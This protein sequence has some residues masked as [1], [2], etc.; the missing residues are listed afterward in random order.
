M[1]TMGG[2]GSLS[3]SDLSNTEP[4]KLLVDQEHVGGGTCALH[5]VV[6]DLSLGATPAYHSHRMAADGR[7]TT[8]SHVQWNFGT[9]RPPE[10]C[11]VNATSPRAMAAL[12]HSIRKPRQL[13]SLPHRPLR[14]FCMW[15]FTLPCSP[16]GAPRPASTSAQTAT[17]LSSFGAERAIVLC[18]FCHTRLCL[19]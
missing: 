12:L 19:S 13:L 17:S 4:W 8:L 6:S 7:D 14:C 16:K 18:R 11:Y 5:K 9:Q 10:H 3:L 2:R 15:G 1:V